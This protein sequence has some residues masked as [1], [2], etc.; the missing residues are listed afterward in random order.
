MNGKEQQ[1]KYIFEVEPL[2]NELKRL[3]SDAKKKT[4][5]GEEVKERLAQLEASISAYK[6]LYLKVY[7]IGGYSIG[8]LVS[9]YVWRFEV[10][11]SPT[12]EE[13]NE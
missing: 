7:C 3:E 9:L 11:R 8:D 10:R 1:M 13:C 2:R 12:V 5:E 4:K 6:V